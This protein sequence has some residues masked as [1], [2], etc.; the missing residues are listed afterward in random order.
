MAS[1]YDQIGG[2]GAVVATVDGLYDRVLGDPMLAGY[3]S[4]V[5]MELQKGH[6]RAFITVALGGGGGYT[7]RDMATAHAGLEIGDREFDL[8]TGHLAATLASLGVPPSQTEAILGR[9]SPLRSE[10][11]EC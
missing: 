1:I 4:D 6:M 7:G 9:I 2:P 10:I 5:A 11:V 8:L 3:F